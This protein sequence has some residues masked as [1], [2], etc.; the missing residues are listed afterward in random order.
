MAHFD[1]R[2]A[3]ARAPGDLR[4]HGRG[5]RGRGASAC[6]PTAGCRF[7]PACLRFYEN[8]RAVRTASS[9]QVRS[10]D[11]PRGHGAMAPLRA[12]AGAARRKRSGRCWRRIRGHRILL[13]IITTADHHDDQPESRGDDMQRSRLRKLKKM[14]PERAA[15]WRAH[16]S[17]RTDRRRHLAAVPRRTRRMPRRSRRRAG[18]GRGHRPEAH[19]EPAGRAG[20]HHGARHR[21]A[22]AAER[23]RASPTT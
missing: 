20:Q 15:H 23:H 12:L 3:G 2:A 13:I 8:E 7:E 19:R 10:P 9:E 1:A 4:A 5:H 17:A 14:G 21:E 11:L 18:R 16:C 6:W 22:R